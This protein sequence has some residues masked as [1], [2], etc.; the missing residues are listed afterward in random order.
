MTYSI[1]AL[2]PK[3]KILVVSVASGSKAVGT[4]V[5]WVKRLVGAVATQGYTNIMYGVEGL[6]LLELGYSPEE[7]LKV[8]INVDSSPELRQV[9]MMDIRGRKAV[10]TGS[11]CPDYKGHAVG[12]NFIVIGNLLRG[13]KVIESVV[14]VLE[15]SRGDIIDIV[16]EALLAGEKAGGDARGNLSAS[17][18][19]A[20]YGVGLS[21]RV[22]ESKHPVR[23]LIKK[24]RTM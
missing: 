18:V 3:K 20:G 19:A 12:R 2:D 9:A 8:L 21:L 10:H 24:Y 16:L 22:D 15:K 7:A 5:P 13:P 1:V 4:R 11:R 14:E 23:E 17:I 6:K